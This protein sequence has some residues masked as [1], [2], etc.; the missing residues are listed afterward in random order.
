MR[1][2]LGIRILSL[3]VPQ[4]VSV[5]REAQLKCAYD[6]EG[7]LLYSVKWYKDDI[8][9]FRYVPSDRPP[10][11]YFQV[12]GIR[13]DMLRSHNGSVVIRGMDAT[14][15]GSYKCEVSA[16]APSFRTIFAEKMIRVSGARATFSGDSCQRLLL[17]VCLA[18]LVLQRSAPWITITK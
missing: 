12:N 15:E 2:I 17:V 6:L 7:D 4:K 11:Q 9:F 1:G 14:S 5:G 10:G 18:I 3:D 8:E 13:V 16:D